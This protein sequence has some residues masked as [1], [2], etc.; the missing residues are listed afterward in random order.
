MNTQ[1]KLVKFIQNEYYYSFSTAS[2][3]C[4]LLFHLD[5]IETEPIREIEKEWEEL[6]GVS[7]RRQCMNGKKYTTFKE[8]DREKE[9]EKHI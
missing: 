5:I 4:I 3:F 9:K 2:N 6:K 1:T 7:E 8:C